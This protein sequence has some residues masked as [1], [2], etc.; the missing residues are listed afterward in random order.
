MMPLAARMIP[1][2]SRRTIAAEPTIATVKN[3]G[4]Y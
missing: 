2:S 4:K 1:D 3:V